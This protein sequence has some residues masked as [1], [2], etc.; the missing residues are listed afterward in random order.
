MKKPLFVTFNYED[1]P[2][3]A[4]SD[5][6]SDYLKSDLNPIWIDLTGVFRK[7]F[8]FPISGY[9]HRKIS[10][11]K[12]AKLFPERLTYENLNINYSWF[13]VEAKV[14]E[15]A[16]K[17]AMQELISRLRNSKPCLI[18][19]N[20]DFQRFKE[21]YLKVFR[22]ACIYL[23]V[24]QPEHI[25]LFNGRFIEER[26]FWDAAKSFGISVK[27]YETFI[28]SWT[29]R[30]HFFEEPTHSPSYRSRVMLEFGEKLLRDDQITFYRVSKDFFESRIFGISNKYTATQESSTIFDDSKPIVSFFHSSQDELVMVDLLDDFWTSQE[31][32]VMETVRVLNEIG[33]FRFVL[34]IHPHLLHKAREE[35]SR[36]N[37]FG[38]SLA[39]QYDWITY[40]PADGV[41]N[42]YDLIKSSKYV[43]TCA[44][45]V[46]VEA[47]YLD[48]PSILLGRA[49][50]EDMGITLNPKTASDLYELLSGNLEESNLFS[51]KLQSLKYGVFLTLGGT[52]FSYVRLNISS[53]QRYVL[54]DVCISK[55]IL[56]RLIQ[57]CEIEFKKFEKLFKSSVLCRHDCWTNSG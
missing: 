47:G 21:L 57:K 22:F 24:N 54:N 56:V 38:K 50:H 53:S 20:A 49:F 16:E 23:Q 11:R 19:N 30:Y 26:A 29:D 14:E 13:S 6:Y 36:W 27:F 44:S 34:R 1:W 33:G 32:A 45:T 17:V 4:H 40:I 51:S 2:L 7:H 5:I 25:I 39:D 35:V 37:A 31:M 12:L 8:E 9:L 10:T 28:D 43:I 41:S 3:A 18:H 52:R 42:T 46:G 48:K 55:S 15:R